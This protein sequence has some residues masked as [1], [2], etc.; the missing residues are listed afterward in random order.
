MEVAVMFE[1]TTGIESSLALEPLEESMEKKLTKIGNSL[2][3]IIEKPILDLLGIGPDTNFRI[4][5]DGK[6]LFLEPLEAPPPSQVQDEPF[7][8]PQV[9]EEP[10]AS[11]PTLQTPPPASRPIIFKDEPFP[12]PQ[13]KEEPQ[14]SLPTLQTPP[15][16]SRPIIFTG[17]GNDV[18]ESPTK[19]R[20]VVFLPTDTGGVVAYH[21]SVGSKSMVLRRWIRGKLSEKRLKPDAWN[22]IKASALKVIMPGDGLPFEPY[23]GKEPW[24]V[25]KGQPASWAEYLARL[26]AEFND[27]GDSA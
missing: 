7:P 9:K 18:V 25:E 11:L 26:E 13:V 8:L 4:R 27:G 20:A 23:D 16:A 24:K 6:S 14:A 17:L 15:P 5:T 3:L 21:V 2:A 1:G 12:L 10:Q 22:T 19:Q